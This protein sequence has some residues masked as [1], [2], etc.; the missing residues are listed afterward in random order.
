MS[1]QISRPWARTASADD[2][3]GAGFFTVANPDEI[4]DR[5]LGATSPK[6]G[7]V[8]I[9]AIK[10]VGPGT[11]MQPMAEGLRVPKLTTLEL[12]PR[13]YHLLMTELPAP[14]PVGSKVPVSLRFEKAG[15]IDIELTVEAHGPVGK[16]A[17]VDG[18]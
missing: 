9:C 11:R 15:T 8:E 17:L 5:L 6:A 3:V 14:W 2:L 12:K 4:H 18:A 13:G 16:Y 10:V 7:K 1:L